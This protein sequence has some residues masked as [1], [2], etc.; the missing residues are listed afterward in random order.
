[1]HIAPPLSAGFITRSWSS[2]NCFNAIFSPFDKFSEKRWCCSC[3]SRISCSTSLQ[4]VF[5]D[6]FVT[7]GQK[8]LLGLNCVYDV[9]LTVGLEVESLCA[10]KKY[11]SLIC[12]KHLNKSTFRSNTLVPTLGTKESPLDRSD[13]CSSERCFED[14][15]I[16]VSL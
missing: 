9:V 2:V 13:N 14:I 3:L 1:M 15:L 7:P 5:I 8:I 11:F 10:L 16:T 12:L 4:K 6:G